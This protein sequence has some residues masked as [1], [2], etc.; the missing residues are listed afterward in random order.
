MM[1]IALAMGLS[2]CAYV[3]RGQGMPRRIGVV[4]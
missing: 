3:H 2:M 1:T 4:V